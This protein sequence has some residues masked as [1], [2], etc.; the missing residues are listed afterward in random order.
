MKIAV[1]FVFVVLLLL[2]SCDSPTEF[3]DNTVPGIRDYVWIVDTLDAPD[4]FYFGMW[5][6]SPSN[7]WTVSSSNW[8]KSIFH[9]DGNKWS[10][11]RVVGLFNINGL[12]GFA[13][14]NIFVGAD[15]GS[16]WR[17]DGNTWNLFVKLKK[18]GT[19]YFAIQNIWGE[20]PNDFYA[21][22]SYPD[23]NGGYNNSVIAHFQNSKWTMLNTDDIIGNVGNLYKNKLDGR[24]YLNTYRI[25]SGEYFDSTLI[26]EYSQGTYK[27]LYSSVWIKGT[28]AD[29][30][31]IDG[32]VYFILGDVI[33]RRIN[34]QFQT[35]LKVNN[36]NFYQRIWGRNSK[37][38]FLLMT[39]GLVHYN[40][41]DLEY[42]FYFNVTPA[43]QIFG[44]A[45]FSN[46]VFFLVYESRTRQKL[47]Y[48]GILN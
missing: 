26:Y 42:L 38:I 47:I 16:I 30:S 22:G 12:Y 14:D 44:A 39:N 4:N 5:G 34:N 40:G 36:S 43:T 29:L 9:F 27:Q 31:F 17:F 15:N 6:S 32:E 2:N 11:S 28:Q 19:D 18:E 21:F 45:L 7:I 10:S 41:T 35:I 1:P 8:D 20:S 3:I 24:I 48:H 25:G 46:E 13:A 23:A 37:D 33:A